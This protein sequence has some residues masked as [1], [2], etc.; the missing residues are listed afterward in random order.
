MVG[1]IDYG[2]G[3]ILSVRNA[4]EWL[5]YECTV[6]QSGDALVDVD[7]IVLPGVGAFRD[8]MLNLHRHGFVTALEKAVFQMKKP[9]LG[10]CLGMQVMARK[11]YENGVH[12]GLG[13][14]DAEVIRLEPDDSS[15]RIPH[16][17]WNE[18]SFVSK[19]PFFER[20]PQIPDFY[21]VHIL[22]YELFQC[23]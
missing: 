10:I 5:G 18:V 15:L 14:L 23:C 20:L 6:C 22:S 1:I 8:C 2:M 11:S 19:S 3:N 9:I 12:E 7:H 21:F 17:G 4:V 13:W 16:I